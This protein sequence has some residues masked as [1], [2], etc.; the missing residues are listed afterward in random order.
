MDFHQIHVLFERFFYCIIIPIIKSKYANCL[1]TVHLRVDSYVVC[2]FNFPFSLFCNL[3]CLIATWT[4]LEGYLT[5]FSFSSIFLSIAMIYAIYLFT[6]RKKNSLQIT[7][8]ALPWCDLFPLKNV[9]F[10]EQYKKINGK[11]NNDKKK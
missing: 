9:E 7:L 1:R 5:R 6:S 10:D 11:N 4:S 3:I 8:M 2:H